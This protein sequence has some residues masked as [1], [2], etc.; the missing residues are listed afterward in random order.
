MAE[1]LDIDPEVK[2]F[3]E[4]INGVIVG[5]AV[6]DYIAGREVYDIDVATPLTPERVREIAES[7]GYKT[8]DVGM[9]FGTVGVVIGDTVLEVTTYR[10]ETYDYVSRKPKVVYTTDIYE[11]LGRRDFTINAIAMTPS[12]EIIDPYGGAEDIREGVIRFVGDP[13]KRILEDPLRIIRGIRFAVKYGFRIDDDSYRAMKEYVG[14][15]SRVAVER[16]R[17]EMLKIING[18]FSEFVRL[19]HEIGV[20]DV[21]FP[22]IGQQDMEYVISVLRKLDSAGA[23]ARLKLA[24]LVIDTDD[25]YS[26]L[27]EMKLPNR[28]VY[29]SGFIAD[30]YEE[31]ISVAGDKEGL[32]QFIVKYWNNDL[33]GISEMAY[34]VDG[35]DVR[36]LVR[37]ARSVSRPKFSR[38]LLGVIEPR[39]RRQYIYGEHVRRILEAWGEY[40]KGIMTLLKKYIDEVVELRKFIRRYERWQ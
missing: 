13:V 23:D 21:V 27:R 17:D 36:D 1:I 30:K 14:E 38:E 12:G 29:S 22:S 15:L 34:I 37:K 28:I 6:R 26:V 16:I 10:K 5:G 31:F 9:R 32:A 18:R 35:I 20:F 3:I 11:D 25:P 24:G 39:S 2:R 8:Y 33:E 19:C 7:M 4:S 40:G